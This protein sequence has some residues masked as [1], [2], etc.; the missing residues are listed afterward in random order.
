MQTA[1]AGKLYGQQVADEDMG[2]CVLMNETRF[3]VG[4]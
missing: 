2:R 1:Q 3:R 4:N